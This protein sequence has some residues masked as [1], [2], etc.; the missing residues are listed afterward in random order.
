MAQRQPKTTFSLIALG[1]SV[2]LLVAILY[3]LKPNFFVAWMLAWSVV[4][5]GLYGYDKA[6]AKM[7]GG[8]V[9]EIVLHMLALVGGVWGA[10]LGMILF[11]HKTRKPVF[12]I[13]LILATVVW[14]GLGYWYFFVRI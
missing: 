4:T 10:W 11:R 14:L 6:Q 8:R 5:L 9:P 2:I 1:L 12:K 13:V 3:F 7:G